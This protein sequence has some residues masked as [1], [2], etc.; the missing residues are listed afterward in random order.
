MQLETKA[1]LAKIKTCSPRDTAQNSAQDNNQTETTQLEELEEDEPSEPNMAIKRRQYSPEKY[2]R[3]KRGRPK[4]KS[5]EEE[6]VQYAQIGNIQ[7][8][9]RMLHCHYI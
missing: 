6:T 5:S 2:Q 1:C 7:P 4:Q 9:K 8:M 3:L